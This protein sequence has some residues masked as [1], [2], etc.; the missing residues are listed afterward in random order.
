[1]ETSVL[2]RR[3]Q[4]MP[5]DDHPFLFIW[6]TTQACDLACVHCRACATPDRHSRE[7]TTEEGKKLL[8]EVAEM[9][10]PLVVL[11]GGDPAKRPD[12]IELVEHG[13]R[14]EL[15]MTVTPSGTGLMTRA[16]LRDLRDAGMKRVAVSIDGPNAEVHDAFR[17]VEGSFAHCMRILEDAEAL[18][19]PRQVNTTIGPH[20][21]KALATMADLVKTTRAVLWSVFVVVPTGRAT[22]SLLFTPQVLENALNELAEI[23][24]FSYF[25]VKTTAAPHF[26]RI[27]LER[28]SKKTLGVLRDVDDKGV[29]RGPRGINDGCGMMFVSHTGDIYPSGFLPLPA[30]NV[31]TE[32]VADVYR[33]DPLFEELR[34]EDRLGGK[35]GYCPFRRVCGGSR[36]RA[37]AMLGDPLAYDPLCPYEP[38]RPT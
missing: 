12:L 2:D 4:K 36:G 24:R 26:R 5:F 23:A 17:K 27:L 38:R 10:T 28:R 9:G 19:I 22:R 7:L 1:M 37:Y 25:D 8:D 18:G 32:R 34:D 30:G 16:I 31:R 6:E 13:T 35:C 33:H 3:P 20:N 15:T 14:A 11:T 21:I 29:V